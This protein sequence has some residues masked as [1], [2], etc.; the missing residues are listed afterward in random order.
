MVMRLWNGILPFNLPVRCCENAVLLLKQR[1][2][3]I[4]VEPVRNYWLFAWLHKK[5]ERLF[6]AF[7]G[8]GRVVFGGGFLVVFSVC[9]A[10]FSGASSGRHWT[11]TFGLLNLVHCV[12]TSH[13]SQCGLET[14]EF[15]HKR[16]LCR[17]ISSVRKELLWNRYESFPQ[18]ILF[19]LFLAFKVLHIDCVLSTHFVHT[20]FIAVSFVQLTERC[21]DRF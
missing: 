20:I 17:R 2:W 19:L 7:P 21:L 16:M 4:S 8:C 3:R 13:G 9:S 10:P 5:K 11:L 6:L 12:C 14:F 15:K 1:Q 18:R